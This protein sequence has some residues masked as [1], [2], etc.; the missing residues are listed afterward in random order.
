MHNNKNRK[1]YRFSFNDSIEKEIK[2]Q[3]FN[4]HFFLLKFKQ[5]ERTIPGLE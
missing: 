1:K 3:N 2:C 4:T 5:N